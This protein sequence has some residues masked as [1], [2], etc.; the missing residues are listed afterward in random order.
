MTG[1]ELEQYLMRLDLKAI[2]AAQLLGVTSRTMQRWLDGEE[3]PGP[4]EQALRAWIT[5]HDLN[6]PWKPDSRSINA[7]DEKSIRA[8]MQH[9]VEQA[10]LIARVEARGGPRTVW[11]IDYSRG[12]AV[13]GKIEVS[14]YR[15]ANG[16]F[17]LSSYT[18]RD[19]E[20]DLHRD[21]EL[22]EDAGYYIALSLLRRDPD[23]GPVILFWNDVSLKNGNRAAKQETRKFPTNEAAIEFAC[24]HMGARNFVDP[25]ITMQSPSDVILDKYDLQQEF[26]TRTNAPG[27]LAALAD[28]VR[29]HSSFFVTN[30]PTTLTPVARANREKHIESLAENIR[31]LA[32]QAREGLATYQQFNAIL[33]ELHAA[34][35]FPDSDLVSTA[36]K[37]LVREKIQP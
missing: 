17:S 11:E 23:F 33:G 27:A 4:A 10:A 30:G 16:G 12:R 37:S 7:N 8:H 31:A 34:G 35:S 6:I 14:F 18:R 15:L 28:Y 2:D 9:A 21:R 25:F 26:E 19:T 32:G 36:A 20:P 29:K 1:V 24:K 5:L 3:I 13:L 22:L